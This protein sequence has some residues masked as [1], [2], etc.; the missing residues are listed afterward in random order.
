MT[1]NSKYLQIREK[2]LLLPM[3]VFVLLSN[4]DDD[5]DDG[6][7]DDDEFFLWNGWPRKGV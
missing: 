1:F 5:D 7:D 3:K 4:D 6:D 2:L